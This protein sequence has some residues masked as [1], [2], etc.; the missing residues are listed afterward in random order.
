[1]PNC[2]TSLQDRFGRSTSNEKTKTLLFTD[3]QLSTESS[4]DKQRTNKNLHNKYSHTFQGESVGPPRNRWNY[5]MPEEAI[6]AN[7]CC[8]EFMFCT[9][10]FREI[11]K[12]AD[13]EGPR[14]IIFLSRFLESIPLQFIYFSIC[15]LSI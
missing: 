14:V 11:V 9:E 3:D 10:I 6:P 12:P 4:E 1:M 15:T 7:L 8:E 2:W 13:I 5:L